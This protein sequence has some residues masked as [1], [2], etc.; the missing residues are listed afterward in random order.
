MRKPV[1]AGDPEQAQAD[2]EQAGDRARA[3]GDLQRGRQPVPRGLSR[4]GVRADGDVHADE[5]GGRREHC[6]DQEADR[7]PPAELVVEAE[8]EERDDRHDRDRHVL[9]AQVGARAFLHGAGDLAH[10]LVAGGLS[11]QPGRQ[12]QPVHH[13]HRAA[14]ERERHGVIHD[15]VHRSTPLTKSSADGFGARG[16]ESQGQDGFFAE[17]SA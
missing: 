5:A 17:A 6:A 9:A 8:Q 13:S 2:D 12:P 7:G 4:T 3:E 16:I 10:A 15:P 11:Q 1:V 14:N